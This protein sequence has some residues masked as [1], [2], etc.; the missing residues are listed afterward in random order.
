MSFVP[1]NR[2]LRA[3]FSGES[4]FPYTLPR[5]NNHTLKPQGHLQTSGS[6]WKLFPS[7][8]PPLNLASRPGRPHSP[9]LCSDR[10]GHILSCPGIWLG[11]AGTGVTVSHG[12]HDAVYSGAVPGL[13][14]LRALLLPARPFSMFAQALSS[15]PSSVLTWLS[16]GSRLIWPP[17]CRD[18]L[19][20]KSVNRGLRNAGRSHWGAGVRPDDP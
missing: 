12:G 19:T 15:P 20:L 7:R 1:L 5:L 16:P 13:C 2:T 14:S 3:G 9:E 17:T 4:G 11:R 18:A 10:P 8:R 6:P